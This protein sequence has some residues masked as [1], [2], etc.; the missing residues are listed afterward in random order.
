MLKIIY[1][2]YKEGTPEPLPTQEDNN[3]QT[4]KKRT[5]IP[6]KILAYTCPA[7]FGFCFK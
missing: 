5:H 1:I 4:K 7:R 6:R 3:F 2:Q